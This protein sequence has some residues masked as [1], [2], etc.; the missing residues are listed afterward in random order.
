MADL[1][2]WRRLQ[3]RLTKHEYRDYGPFPQ[4]YQVQHIFEAQGPIP[5]MVRQQLIE[6]HRQSRATLRD[7]VMSGGGAEIPTEQA[8]APSVDP[9]ET[10]VTSTESQ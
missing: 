7:F 1:G 5:E 9:G 8:N 3:L 2:Y 6:A 10:H 4:S